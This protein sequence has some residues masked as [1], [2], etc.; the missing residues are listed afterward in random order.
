MGHLHFRYTPGLCTECSS[1]F[2]WPCS[3]RSQWHRLP[4]RHRPRYSSRS[5]NLSTASTRGIRRWPWA[6]CADQTSIL[7]EFPPH[8]WHGAGA[9]A[10]W[11]NDFD[12][13]AKKNGITNGVVKLRKASHVDINSDYAYVV[14]PANYTFEQKGKAVSE[15]G[16]IITLSLQKSPT[17]WR[18]TGWAWAKR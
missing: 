9:C 13:D 6:A 12:A 3:P 1:H 4:D 18:I 7:D 11:L 14:V 5:I 15:V 8:E 2:H 17:G 10:R 16:S